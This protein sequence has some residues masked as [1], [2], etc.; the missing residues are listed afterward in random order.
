MQT[1]T[2]TILTFKD[3]IMDVWY[4]FLNF[5]Y[6]IVLESILYSSF[7]IILTILLT[8]ILLKGRVNVIHKI[9]RLTKIHKRKEE[10][11]ISLLLS[12]TRYII[13]IIAAIIV[14][15]EVGIETGPI[16]AS[17]GIL[18]LAIGFG[19]QNFVKDIISGFFILFE[20]WMR[21]GDYVTIGNVS[22]TVEET[23]LR[24][25]IIREWSGKQV[26]LL[27]SSITQLV[28]YNRD[29]MRPIV[30]FNIPYEYPTDIIKKLIDE[31]CDKVNELHFDRL[32][33]D[34]F[35]NIVEP[36][37]LYGIT[38]VENNALGAKYTIVGLVIDDEYFFMSKEIR[39]IT[40]EHLRVNDIQVAYPKRIY[41]NDSLPN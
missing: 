31:A 39:R 19:A 25:T 4:S 5:D 7:Q 1:D 37:Q 26:H 34:S 8:W 10:T 22:G 38:D 28:N 11:L 20:D 36:I 18:G 27:N 6:S 12:L 3:K 24:S 13:L 29:S 41:S 16:L 15:G 35:G 33:K 23:G 2:N 9:F 17:A 32:L 14:L 30:S 21:I 40:L